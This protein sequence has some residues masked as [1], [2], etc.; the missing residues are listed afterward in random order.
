MLDLWHTYAKT[1]DEIS[2]LCWSLWRLLC[3]LFITFGL[4]YKENCLIIQVCEWALRG[5]LCALTSKDNHREFWCSTSHKI[6]LS[7]LHCKKLFKNRTNGKHL[8]LSLYRKLSHLLT[9]NILVTFSFP[10]YFTND[11]IG[12]VL[13]R[14]NFILHWVSHSSKSAPTAI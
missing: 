1:L 8:T 11:T 10:L 2:E 3:W 7:L 12:S 13:I 4:Y 6:S 9:P 14:Y 5:I